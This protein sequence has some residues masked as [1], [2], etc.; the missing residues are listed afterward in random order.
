MADKMRIKRIDPD[1][2]GEALKPLYEEIIAKR[3]RLWNIYAAQAHLPGVMKA[4]L[5]FYMKLMF[6]AGGLPRYMRELIG[7]YVS[8]LNRCAY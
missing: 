2:A 8:F 3:G 5:D 1:E 6:G 4:H 7:C